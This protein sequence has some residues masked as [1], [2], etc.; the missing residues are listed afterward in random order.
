MDRAEGQGG[1]HP[2][3]LEPG[4][5]YEM[6]LGLT[7]QTIQMGTP[8]HHSRILMNSQQLADE[9]QALADGAKSRILSVGDE[10]YSFGDTQKFESLPLE[11]LFD[12]MEEELQD[13]VSYA[14]MLSIRVRRV[15]SLL[16]SVGLVGEQP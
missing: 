4:A 5:V 12:W 8:H 1:G 14:T 3:D 15:R 6:Q 11:E 16:Q 10:Q 13:V 7:F 9:V 2:G